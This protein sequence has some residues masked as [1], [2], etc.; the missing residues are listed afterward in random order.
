MAANPSGSGP[1]MRAE[2]NPGLFRPQE[3]TRMRVKKNRPVAIPFCAAHSTAEWPRRNDIFH[4][5]YDII[6]KIK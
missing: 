3:R 4:I 6:L 1:G 2:S 5:E